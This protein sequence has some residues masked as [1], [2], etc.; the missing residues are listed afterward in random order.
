MDIMS[1]VRNKT[2]TNKIN[3][4]A[5]KY[6]NL[7]MINIYHLFSSYYEEKVDKINKDIYIYNCMLYKI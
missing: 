3:Q 6:Q 2:L 7:N 4:L 1:N 5:G